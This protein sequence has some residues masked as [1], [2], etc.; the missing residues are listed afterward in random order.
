MAEKREG[1]KEDKG[2]KISFKRKIGENMPEMTAELI[3][4]SASH[5]IAELVANSYDADAE[6]VRMTYDF[7]KDKFIVPDEALKDFMIY[8]SKK[9]CDSYFRTPRNTIRAFVDMLSLL[10]QN[11][12]LDWKSLLLNVEILKEEDPDKPINDTDISPSSEEIN[13]NDNDLATFKL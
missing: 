5:G 10:E 8:C 1:K 13:K 6:N 9:I 4:R 12:N 3:M 11:P 7:D 2:R